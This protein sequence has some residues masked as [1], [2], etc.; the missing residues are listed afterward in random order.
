MS[1]DPVS[2]GGCPGPD[3]APDRTVDS[4]ARQGETSAQP[5]GIQWLA[6][7]LPALMAVMRSKLVRR[8]FLI[9][10]L[11]LLGVALYHQS[12]TLWSE[13]QRLSAPVL[14][15]AFVAGLCGLL[16]S[17]MVWRTLLAD[18]GSKLSVPE[19][20]RIFFIGQLTKYVPGSVWPVLAQMELA[21]DRGV[22]RD[23][24]V[25]SALLSYATMTCTGAV[26][27]V[28]TLP[29]A[30]GGSFGH[31]FWV[32]FAIPL[33]AVL[34]SPP[35]LNRLFALLLRVLRRPPLEHVLSI[36]G[37]SLTMSWALAGWAC[38]GFMTYILLRQLAGHSSGALLASVGGYALSWVAGFVA[39]FAPAGAGVREAVMV[40]ALSSRTTAATALT[41]ALVTRALAVLS[42]GVTGAIAAALIGRRRLQELRAG[43]LQ[44][45]PAPAAEG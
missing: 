42:D 33:A 22:P 17:F 4:S 21:A 44:R 23:R 45:A 7:R 34:L 41:I 10:V 6:T 11:A 18:L 24:S 25:L 30:A 15:L 14:L 8:T 31:Y 27:A 35:V 16:C 1:I 9:A 19:A 43:R 26:V 38:N 32:L 13:L 28:V 3:P 12:G 40:A 29:F 37:L 36:R 5:L 2:A 39:V 20:W